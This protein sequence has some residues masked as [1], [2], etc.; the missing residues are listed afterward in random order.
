MSRFD[1]D[2]HELA[3]FAINDSGLYHKAQKGILRELA[4]KWRNGTYDVA[5]AKVLW[6]YHA[7]AAAAE[8]KRQI[9]RTARFDSRSQRV[10]A[11]EFENYYRDHVRDDSHGGGRDRRRARRSVSSRRTRVR[12]RR[13]RRR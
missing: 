10:A 13:T 3:L 6:E 5:L 2:G 12:S 9:D 8:Y 7:H 4:R 1:N 11:A